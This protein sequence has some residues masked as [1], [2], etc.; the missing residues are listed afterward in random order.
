MGRDRRVVAFLGGIDIP[1]LS[2]H[3]I[4]GLIDGHPRLAK[5]APTAQNG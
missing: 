3:C 2:P 4:W 1:T 5:R